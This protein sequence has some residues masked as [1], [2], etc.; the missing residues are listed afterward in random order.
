MV[1]TQ[2]HHRCTFSSKYKRSGMGGMHQL[3]RSL[4][5]NRT[6]RWHA[7]VDLQHRQFHQNR[8]LNGN[9]WLWI[10]TSSKSDN[11]KRVTHLLFCTHFFKRY[12]HFKIDSSCCNTAICTCFAE[13]TMTTWKIQAS[14][15]YLTP[16]WR[17]QE[18]LLKHKG[19]LWKG[20]GSWPHLICI[21]LQV[22]ARG[23]HSCALNA[24]CML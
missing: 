8:E 22:E 12:S 19:T 9:L 11:F 24:A 2:D 16:P 7:K 13:W 10:G 20:L 21:F 3:R 14:L 6:R 1:L 5:Q 15:K 17:G 18:Q 23:L 4:I